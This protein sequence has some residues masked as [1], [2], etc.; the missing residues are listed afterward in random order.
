MERNQE[1][2]A[3]KI[4]VNVK[5]LG[6]KKATVETADYEII[7]RPQ[8]VRELICSVAEAEVNAY[9][10][11]YEEAHSKENLQADGEGH[12]EPGILGWLTKKEM[13]DQARSGK[14]GLR[15]NYGEK[16]AELQK[17]QDNAVQCFEDGIYRIFLD[18]QPLE[19]LDGPIEITEESEFTFVRLVMLAGRM[20]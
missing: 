10:R 12:Q 7:G 2:A 18:G 9:N 13:E 5:R 4:R 17:A 3:L 15:V 8:T 19:E 20:W 6:K 14:I 11:R 16:K 1:E